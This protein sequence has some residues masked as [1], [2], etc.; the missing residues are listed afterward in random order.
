V[1]VPS[2]ALTGS[3]RL[4]VITFQ[5]L[6]GPG[7]LTLRGCGS[8]PTRG[9]T[10]DYT[11]HILPY[12][13][14]YDTV[15]NLTLVD[16]QDTCINAFQ[17]ISVAGNGTAFLVQNGGSATFIARQKIVFHPVSTVNSG[18]YLHAR[19]TS[20]STFCNLVMMPVM[21]ATENQE[22]EN[23]GTES[24]AVEAVPKVWFTVWPN[25][26]SGNFMIGFAGN[27]GNGHARIQCYDM[28]GSLLI[29]QVILTDIRHEFSLP[30]KQPGIYL[31]KLTI[32]GECYTR[33][34]VKY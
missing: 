23:S 19:I 16:G 24:V 34:I 33:K 1:T 27:S 22:F 18:G 21:T 12:I 15:Q 4:R 11:I 29:D 10:E 2:D 8:N 17:T 32:N 26:T 25:P 3:T 7:G 5:Q 30:D 20:D 14:D 31:L 28:V 9:E 13:P 6:P